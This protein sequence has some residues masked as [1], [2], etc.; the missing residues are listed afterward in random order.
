M[1][2][3]DKIFSIRTANGANKKVNAR[4]LGAL[5]KAGNP[6]GY[7]VSDE[8]GQYGKFTK[9]MK[10][11]GITDLGNMGVTAE[12]QEK[13]TNN[14]NAGKMIEQGL[15][16]MDDAD[17]QYFEDQARTDE[18]VNDE[19]A[20]IPAFED[21]EAYKTTNDLMNEMLSTINAEGLSKYGQQAQAEQDKAYQQANL[22]T[23]TTYG[24][25]GTNAWDKMVSKIGGVDSNL[26][27]S[28]AN[29]YNT[30][31]AKSLQDNNFSNWQANQNILSD[32]NALKESTKAEYQKTASDLEQNKTNYNN[33]IENTIQSFKQGLNQMRS[34][35]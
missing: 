30:Q 25:Q 22:N 6:Q 20:K 16:P 8:N 5:I 4:E 9:Y 19:R 13:I 3:D 33:T 17:I 31:K 29:Q 35:K 18:L 26:S 11:M 24:N 14:P 32:D 15:N 28:V 21:T 10:D 12:N 34:Y 27:G 7:L 1:F 23:S 2:L